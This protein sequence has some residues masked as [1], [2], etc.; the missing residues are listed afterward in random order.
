MKTAV[1]M[2]GHLRTFD[3][4]LPNLHWQVFRHFG[5]L[6]FFVSTVEDEDAPKIRA[7]DEKYRG[8]QI[9]V[10]S[11]PSQPDFS[12]E[13]G[14][15]SPGT[16][17]SHEPYTISVPPQAVLAQLWQLEQVYDFYL[18]KVS[19]AAPDLIIRCRPDLWF[20]EFENGVFNQPNTCHV[21][22]FGSFGGVNDR[23][24]VLSPDA[25]PFYFRTFSRRKKTMEEGC[26]LH[27]ESLVKASLENGGVKIV[28]QN[29]FFS[30]Y[31]KNGEMRMP[32]VIASDI[33]R[34]KSRE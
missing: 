9:E 14:P 7:L 24:A 15:W 11:V 5:D 30:S 16:F 31:R 23:F 2:S 26:P 19:S 20:H 33:L 6:S 21:P 34:M 29:W 18:G 25:A 22:A 27:P 1:L 17:Y 32:E 3:R 13:V 12:N 8:C 10:H 4:C 28:K